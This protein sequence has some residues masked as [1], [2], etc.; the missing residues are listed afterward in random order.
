MLDY[1][2]AQFALSDQFYRRQRQLFTWTPDYMDTACLIIA[3]VN[4]YFSSRHH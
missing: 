1:W 2:I 4:F 3:G